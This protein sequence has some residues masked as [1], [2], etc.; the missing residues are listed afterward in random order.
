MIPLEA[1]TPIAVL[2]TVFLCVV[3]WSVFC[4]GSWRKP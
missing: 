1:S 2:I 4:A 3:A